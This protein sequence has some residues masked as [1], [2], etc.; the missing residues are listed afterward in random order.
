MKSGWAVE[1]PL[2]KFVSEYTHTRLTTRGFTSF[3]CNDIIK[4][5]I[6]KIFV[7]MVSG[8]NSWNHDGIIWIY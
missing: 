8:N 4:A 6:P 3:L 1:S 7:F 5:R 2:N